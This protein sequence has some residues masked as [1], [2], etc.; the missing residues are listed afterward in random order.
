MKPLI[1]I[2][3]QKDFVD[4]VLG[5]KEAQAIADD[6]AKLMDEWDGPVICTYD[7]HKENYMETLEG[8]Y[9]PVKHCVE[10]SL[11]WMLCEPVEEAAKRLN[12]ARIR[13]PSFGSTDL[14][15]LVAELCEGD[16]DEIHLC[17]VC[18][19][20]CV[21]SNAM[22]LK[23]FF[24]ETPVFV[25]ADLCAGVTPEQHVTALK[26]MKPCQIEVI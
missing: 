13:K 25:H 10:W 1:V 4:G 7:T 9:L 18:T 19:D 3:M 15:G 2:D 22:M 12:A 6:V 5:T 26:A 8:H 21:I 14:P 20:I 17:G 23:A 16:I 24:P 11:G